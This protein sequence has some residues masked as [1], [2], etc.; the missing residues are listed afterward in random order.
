M[1]I[2]TEDKAKLL[3][4]YANTETGEKEW[5]QSLVNSLV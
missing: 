4:V 3:L 2:T 5:V 1:E